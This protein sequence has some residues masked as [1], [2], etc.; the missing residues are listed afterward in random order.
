[1]LLLLPFLRL[2]RDAEWICSC[3]VWGV[4]RFVRFWRRGRLL[5]L[6]VIIIIIIVVIFGEDA[7]RDAGY[8]YLLAEGCCTLRG[9]AQDH[10]TEGGRQHDVHDVEPTE[11]ESDA[12]LSGACR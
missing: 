11:P 9:V 5:L 7:H 10:K 6:L 3:A 8:L 12:V 4:G 2:R 1:M